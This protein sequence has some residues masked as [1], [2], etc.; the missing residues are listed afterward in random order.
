MTKYDIYNFILIIYIYG[1]FVMGCHLHIKTFSYE[2]SKLDNCPM[3]EKK[4]TQY[5]DGSHNQ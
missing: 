2:Q 3:I 1:V 5:I 4:N